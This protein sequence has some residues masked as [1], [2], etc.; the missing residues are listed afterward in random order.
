M[1]CLCTNNWYYCNCFN[2][3]L[4]NPRSV[5]LF[6]FFL[7]TFIEIKTT[8]AQW[9]TLESPEQVHFTALCFQRKVHTAS[10]AMVL[11]CGSP[12]VQCIWERGPDI[13]M[14]SSGQAVL[15][16]ARN[17]R[18]NPKHALQIKREQNETTKHGMNSQVFPDL[19]ITI[20]TW[21]QNVRDHQ[22]IYIYC[23]NY[24]RFAIKSEQCLESVQD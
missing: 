14:L 20:I 4:E 3:A 9:P 21:L 23:C 2:V 16:V 5:K 10:P 13:E 24:S 6:K 22:L 11:F 18:A 15:P 7:S 17:Q 1:S 12:A 8:R 19:S